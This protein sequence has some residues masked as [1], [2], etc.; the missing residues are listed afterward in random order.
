M[1]GAAGMDGR[2]FLGEEFDGVLS[3]LGLVAGVGSTGAHPLG[4]N[5]VPT[6]RIQRVIER[7]GGCRDGPYAGCGCRPVLCASRRLHW[8]GHRGHHE[9]GCLPGCGESGHTH[10]SC[11][12]VPHPP[13]VQCCGACV[14]RGSASVGQRV[15]EW[16]R[17]P[18]EEEAGHG[19]S[20]RVLCGRWCG[21]HGACP[22]RAWSGIAVS[23]RS[24][25]WSI[26]WL[27]DEASREVVR[28][29]VGAGFSASL[30]SRIG[31]VLNQSNV[32]WK[33]LRELFT[34]FSTLPRT[35]L[36]RLKLTR[37][38]WPRSA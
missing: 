7:G 34:T 21:A 33:L 36:L 18:A 22:P 15:P 17:L 30:G 10:A 35:R 5:T 16:I 20:R 26:G 19:P 13:P 1:L 32:P 3:G 37:S 23:W 28:V 12:H 38:A 9:S 14:Q 24:S 29:C 27:V 8:A 6:L 11:R 4:M 31:V 2:R 25:C